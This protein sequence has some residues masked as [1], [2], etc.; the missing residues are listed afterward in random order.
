[1]LTLKTAVLFSSGP[2]LYAALSFFAQQI[3]KSVEAE[4]A[5]QLDLSGVLK[6]G[7]DRRDVCGHFFFTPSG[8]WVK[9]NV[10]WG[11]KCRIVIQLFLR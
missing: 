3:L 10:A 2:V 4:R 6:S 11:V 5:A 7:P 1:M 8:L 9:H